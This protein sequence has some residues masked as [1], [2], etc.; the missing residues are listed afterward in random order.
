LYYE[1]LSVLWDRYYGPSG[2]VIPISYSN[3]LFEG[4]IHFQTAIKHSNGKYL[5]WPNAILDINYER[6]DKF[7]YERFYGKWISRVHDGFKEI[8]TAVSGKRQQQ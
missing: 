6:Q 3:R 5:F 1:F 4:D 7:Y 2:I 8:G